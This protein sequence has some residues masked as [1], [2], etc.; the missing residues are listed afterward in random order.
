MARNTESLASRMAFIGALVVGLICSILV[1]PQLFPTEDGS[2]NVARVAFT[3]A[4]GAIGAAVG[5]FAG[6]MMSGS[7]ASP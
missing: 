1:G 2:F 7:T 4:G 3:A 6:K 5:W